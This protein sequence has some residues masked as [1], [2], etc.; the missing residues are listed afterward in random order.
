MCMSGEYGRGETYGVGRGAGVGGARAGGGA[1]GVGGGAGLDL[2]GCGTGGIGRGWGGVEAG[3]ELGVCFCEEVRVEHL[4]IAV[5]RLF[6]ACDAGRTS[7]YCA[8]RSFSTLLKAARASFLDQPA[9]R[10]V[11]ARSGWSAV[12]MPVSQSWNM[13]CERRS[14]GGWGA[15]RT[16]RVP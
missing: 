15:Q 12:Y 5:I 9:A 4:P 10:G 1:R 7:G 13:W 6:R 2:C 16:T 3:G 14:R 8:C 11:E